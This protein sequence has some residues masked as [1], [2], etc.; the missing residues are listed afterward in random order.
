M[1]LTAAV[2]GF[3]LDVINGVKGDEIPAKALPGVSFE[4]ALFV[5]AATC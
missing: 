2:T 5:V 3:D 1:R 4:G